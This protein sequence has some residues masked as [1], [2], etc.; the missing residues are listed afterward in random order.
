MAR[1]ASPPVLIRPNARRALGLAALAGA[2]ACSRGDGAAGSSQGDTDRR[3]EA[4]RSSE[5]TAAAARPDSTETPPLPRPIDEMTSA[6]VHQFIAQVG[7]RFDHPASKPG[8]GAS[9]LKPDTGCSAE[10]HGT[11]TVAPEM[12]AHL[13]DTA[14]ITRSGVLIAQ[15]RFAHA[16]CDEGRFGFPRNAAAYWVVDRAVDGGALRS[17]FMTLRG[18]RPDALSGA[19][20]REH[21]FVPCPGHVP[22]PTTAAADFPHGPGLTEKC[23]DV[24]RPSPLQ[25][26]ATHDGSPWVSCIAG[27][28]IANP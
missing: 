12:G 1:P 5:S 23:A 11:V 24:K 21:V 18:E 10:E 15:I 20:G 17:R 14:R 26:K 16:S 19:A 28:C 4:A 27:C 25:S 3:A 9:H 8:D 22:R 7:V 13:V 2:A 6:E